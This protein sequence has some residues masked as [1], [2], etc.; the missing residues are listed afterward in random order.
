[1]L[2]ASGKSISRA[3]ETAFSMKFI[4]TYRYTQDRVRFSRLHSRS[5]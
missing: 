3:A 2:L 1:M 4:S 5:T